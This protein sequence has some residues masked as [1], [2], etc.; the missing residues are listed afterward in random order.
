M[1]QRM[2]AESIKAEKNCVQRQHNRSNANAK[3]FLASNRVREPYAQPR[4]IGKDHDKQG[5]QIKHIA[6]DVLDDERE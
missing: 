5:R 6:V 3:M 2:A 4:I 1:P